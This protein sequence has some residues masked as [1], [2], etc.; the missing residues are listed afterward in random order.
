MLLEQL[1]ISYSVEKQDPVSRGR[2]VCSVCLPAVHTLLDGKFAPAAHKSYSLLRLH[3]NHSAAAS[4][5]LALA[6]T[7]PPLSALSTL[8]EFKKINGNAGAERL[9]KLFHTS[10]ERLL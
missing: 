9:L 2:S 8:V 10:A 1:L 7:P 3:M 6:N 4:L 5:Q